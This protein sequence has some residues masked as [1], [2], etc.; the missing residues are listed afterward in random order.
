MAH[1]K[2]EKLPIHGN[3]KNVRYYLSTEDF[4]EAMMLIIAK[5]TVGET[6]NVGSMESYSNIE[7]AEIICC[8]FGEKLQD[9]VNFVADRPF[10]DR[11]YA[12][13]SKK[14]EALGWRPRQALLEKIPQIV[15]WYR[16]NAHR[17]LDH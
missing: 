8:E 9:K 14:I 6:Y 1:I 7:I 12:M 16:D 5:D 2:K 15:Q 10:N 11:R 17:Y 4:T 13:S 3:G